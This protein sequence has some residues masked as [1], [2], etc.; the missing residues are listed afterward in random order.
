MLRGALILFLLIFISSAQAQIDQP[1][2]FEIELDIFD[3]EFY[4][5]SGEEQ[6]LL[7]YKPLKV[8]DGKNQLWKFIKLDT[9]LQVQWERDFYINQ[10]HV[11]R[12]FDYS[13]SNFSLLYQITEKSSLDLLLLQL[14]EFNGDTS[15]HRIKNLVRLEL[16]QFEMNPEA[17][18]IAGYYN[19]D[20]VVIHY[21]LKAKKSKVLPGIYGHKTEL[22]HVR[23]DDDYI[24]ILLTARTFDNS[25]TLTLKTYDPEGNYLD[26]Y[27]FQPANDVGLVF[28]RV[29]KLDI[30]GSL[31]CGTYGSRKSDFSRGLFI[32]NHSEESKQEIRYF[33]YADL[34]NFFTYLK[35]KRQKRI[36]EKI[37][38]KKVKGKK[39]KFNYRLLVHDIMKNGDEYIMLGEAFYP[40]YNSYGTYSPYSSSYGS[41]S[42]RNYM[43]PSFAG[44]RYTHAVVIGFNEKGEILWDNS[45]QIS[46]ILSFQLEQFVHADVRDDKIVLLYLYENEIRTKI[47]SGSE[48]VE[49]RSFNNMRLTFEDD[50]IND[51][52]SYSNV[53]GL[54]KWY[55]HTYFAYGV[56]K[57]KNLR[58]T[59]VKLNRRV[60][61]INKVKY[62]QS[63]QPQENPEQV[64]QT[65]MLGKN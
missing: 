38:R 2:R 62:D 4:V 34:D 42:G 20:P 44:Y 45:F 22:A 27:T 15:M 10:T 60:F 7:V 43:P 57:I 35:A 1:G 41:Y 64:D 3:D 29:A 54:D 52:S 11:Y 31:I 16:D 49:G 33:N 5:L 59:G 24:N 14:D 18:V 56:Q 65:S 40:K 13:G 28:G 51:K 19:T 61:Y 36:S 46:D 48:V 58:D 9:T 53:G 23:V 63:Y 25:N 30:E 6:G 32:A 8:F 26:S 50:V 12:G 17:A 47:I 55:D 21:D 39:V 37:T